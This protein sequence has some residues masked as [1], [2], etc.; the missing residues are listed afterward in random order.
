MGELSIAN[1]LDSKLKDLNKYLK[2]LIKVIP[3]NLE[4]YEK[5]S[6]TKAVCERYFEKIVEATI[7][8]GFFVIKLNK[9]RVPNLDESVFNILAENNIINLELSEKLFGAKSMRNFII[10]QYG[11]IDDEKIFFTIKDELIPDVKEFLGALE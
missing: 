7:D 1:R 2:F 3:D 6:I 8:I 9:L 5:D 11:G 10:H 4:V